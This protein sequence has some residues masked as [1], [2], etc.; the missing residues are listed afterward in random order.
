M[1][2]I[3]PSSGGMQTVI[4]HFSGIPNGLGNISATVTPANPPKTLL[5]WSLRNGI[6]VIV[7]GSVYPIGGANTAVMTW[8]KDVADQTYFASQSIA[9]ICING[10]NVSLVCQNGVAAGTWDLYLE[11]AF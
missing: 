1:G 3:Y 5:N 9:S 8:A 6:F 7:M 4:E 2:F 10:S 11:Y